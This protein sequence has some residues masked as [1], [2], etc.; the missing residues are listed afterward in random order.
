MSGLPAHWSRG[1]IKWDTQ[2]EAGATPPTNEPTFWLDGD[3][4]AGTP[5]VAIADM[6]RRTRVTG[7]VKSLSHDAMV[8]RSMPIGEPGILLLAMYASVGEVAFLDTHATWNQALLGIQPRADRV[9]PRFLRYVLLSMR[10]DLLRDVRSNTQSNLNAGQ[11]GDLWFQRPPLGEQ[12]A[13]ADFLDRETARIDTLIEEQQRLVD[14]LRGR[15]KATVESAVFNGVDGAATTES[16]EPWLPSVPAHWRVTQLGFVAETLAGYAFP[17]DGFSADERN[18]RLL[19][20]I[21]IKPGRTDWSESVYWDVDE[22]PIPDDYWLAEGDLVLGMDRP[23]VGGGVRV[24]SISVG[25][26]PALLLQRV[27][28]IRPLGTGSRRY[29]MYVLSTDAF[30]SNLEPL[31]TGVS[32][33]HISEW[34]VRK[35]R[36]P[37]PSPDEQEQIAAHLDETT[38]KIDAL[39][40]ESEKFIELS[41]ERRAALITAAVTGQIDVRAVV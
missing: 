19:R 3:D 21:N 16:T 41:R 23:F 31:F 7:T 10:E 32:V 18:V 12:R 15:R 26:T 20:G 5:F 22:S 38:S 39:V 25:D 11:I 28:R 40:A 24:A 13:I 35:F 34:Q 37:M 30:L 2:I 4:P 8:A 9:D 14:L 27:L 36:M 29:L 6:S 17:G 1:R 33:P